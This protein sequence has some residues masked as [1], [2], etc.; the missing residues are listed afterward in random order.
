MS[1]LTFTEESIYEWLLLSSNNMWTKLQNSCDPFNVDSR[2]SQLYSPFEFSGSLTKP[3]STAERSSTSIGLCHYRLTWKP[4][5]VAMTKPPLIRL[6]YSPKWCP[7]SQGLCL[8]TWNRRLCIF[9]VFYDIRKTISRG[10]ARPVSGGMYLIR[11]YNYS[12]YSTCSATFS[13]S[14]EADR[15]SVSSTNGF[16]IPSSGLDFIR[17]LLLSRGF[18][19]G[20]IL[21]NIGLPRSLMRK[22]F[23]GNKA[24]MERGLYRDICN[25]PHNYVILLFRI[26]FYFLTT[27]FQSVIDRKTLLTLCWK[28]RSQLT[29]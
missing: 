25:W 2:G 4:F 8:L 29:F 1:L 5:Q 6:V 16:D 15:W 3:L 12:T 10:K 24:T 7:L 23:E 14:G 19:F 26:L 18:H 22:S 27:F 11:F 20:S 21:T 28:Y 17:C 13:S 9:N